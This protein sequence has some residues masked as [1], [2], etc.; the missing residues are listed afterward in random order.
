MAL[1][2]NKY[3]AMGVAVPDYQR[4]IDASHRRSM[5]SARLGM[6]QERLGMGQ[7]AYPL[8]AWS[9]TH[10]KHGPHRSHK[11]DRSKPAINRLLSFA[12]TKVADRQG[13][14]AETLCQVAQTA[15]DNASLIGPMRVNS[16]AKKGEEGIEHE[17]RGFCLL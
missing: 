13:D 17:E 15:H 4:M 5:G 3:P 14:T 7:D 6:E 2:F 10:N 9:L 11:V 8:S 16:G 12:L 1:G